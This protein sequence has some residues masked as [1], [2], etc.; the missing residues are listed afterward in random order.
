MIFAAVAL[1]GCENEHPGGPL[2]KQDNAIAFGQVATR[3]DISDIQNGGFGVWATFSNSEQT[4][5]PLMENTHV[6]Y[7]SGAWEYDDTKYWIDN[8]VFNFVAAYPYDEAGN[9]F[10]FANN[11]VS[12]SVRETPST[13]DYLLATAT[14]DT[15]AEGFDPGAAVELK[16]GHLL[17]NVNLQIWRDGGKHQNDDMRIKKVTLSNIR[18]GGTYSSSTNAWT[19]LTNETLDLKYE[20]NNPTAFDGAAIVNEDGSLTFGGTS[21][22][23]FEDM[24]LLPQTNNNV[25]LKIEYEL[26]R[27]NAADWETAELETELPIKWEVGKKYTYNVVLSSVKYITVYYIQTKV[28]PWGT[29]QVGGT[30][31]IK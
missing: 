2:H 11:A 21:S 20:N 22:K 17:T 7:E 26:K 15:S 31:I 3:A 28:D 19:S 6:T 24:L 4:N 18:K 5:Y 10:T 1:L 27:N 30:V 16:F 9:I 23:P 14:V 25:S 8:T 13:E 12:L 29:P